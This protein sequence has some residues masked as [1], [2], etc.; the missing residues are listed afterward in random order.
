IPNAAATRTFSFEVIHKLFGGIEWSPGFYYIPPSHGESILTGR[1]YF[2]IDAATDPYAPPQPGAHGAKLIPFVRLNKD[3]DDPDDDAIVNTPVFVRASTFAKNAGK[4]EHEYIYFGMYSQERF[5][6]RLDY[7][8]MVEAV[9]NNVKMHWAEQL[10]DIGR[11][12][13]VTEELM[14]HFWKK[15]EFEGDLADAADASP[16]DETSTTAGAAEEYMDELKEWESEAKMK[17][18]M[19]KKETILQAF[20][21]ADSDDPAGLRLWWE[22]LQCTTYDEGFYNMLVTEQERLR[23]R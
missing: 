15:P 5:S 1:A 10:A 7:D 17:V 4:N 8:R 19:M 16:K 11:P 2:A 3:E 21:N 20:E 22:Y 14:K 13:W 6:D 12:A 23:K 18:G 9:P